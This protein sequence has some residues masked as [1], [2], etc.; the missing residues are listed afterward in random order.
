[1][2]A[3]LD[4]LWDEYGDTVS[5]FAQNV[6]IVPDNPNDK[7]VLLFLSAKCGKIDLDKE[8][9]EGLSKIMDA[10]LTTGTIAGRVPSALD[11]PDF[12][13]SCF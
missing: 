11:D 8:S 7:V 12:L 13:R 4:N 2:F 1:M 5:Q 3:L 6:G 10:V 9:S